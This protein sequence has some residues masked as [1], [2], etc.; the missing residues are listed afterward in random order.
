MSYRDWPKIVF[1]AL[2]ARPLV[3]FFIGLTVHHRE[4]LPR[5]GPAI[6]VANHN[7]HLDT[8]V[9]MSLFSLRDLRRVRPVAAA[10]YFLSSRV[11]AWFSRYVIGIV[12]IARGGA[13]EHAFDDCDAALRNGDILILFPEGTRGEPEKLGAL[14]KGFYYLAAGHT[15]CRIV[16]AYMYGLGK[17]LPKGEALLV[18]FNIQVAIGETFVLPENATEA[19]EQLERRLLDLA[20]ECHIPA[21]HNM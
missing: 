15:H 11:R 17:S 19:T 16:P 8:L 4:R 13:V 12:P 14:K 7:S 6:I 21:D 5:H 9:L 18:P 2:L 1:F 10:D 3:L 20:S